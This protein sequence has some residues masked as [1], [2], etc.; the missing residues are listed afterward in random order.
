MTCRVSTTTTSL[1]K[2]VQLLHDAKLDPDHHRCGNVTSWQVHNQKSCHRHDNMHNRIIGRCQS[3]KPCSSQHGAT[4]HTSA[5][6][7]NKPESTVSL[8][9]LK[10]TSR[11]AQERTFCDRKSSPQFK[12][13]DNEYV[14]QR[15]P[16]AT[17]HVFPVLFSLGGS[18]GN[19]QQT[20]ARLARLF[21]STS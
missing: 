7:A 10:N 9:Y 16:P 20:R 19:M 21:L 1:S 17:P 2:R 3:F 5:Q 13:T 6:L 15:H 18:C 12:R 14:K 11:A 4:L 8:P